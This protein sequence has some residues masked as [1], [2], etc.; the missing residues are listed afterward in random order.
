MWKVVP[1]TGISVSI[2]RYAAATHPVGRQ[3]GAAGNTDTRF[4]VQKAPMWQTDNGKQRVQLDA[5]REA[6]GR[7]E[8][9]DED[10]VCG[11]TGPLQQLW[12]K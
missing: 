5:M 8:T 6:L 4:D 7:V 1:T 9:P 10:P 11:G 3:P 2:L 12:K